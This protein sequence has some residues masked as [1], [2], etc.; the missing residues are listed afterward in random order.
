LKAVKLAKKS[1][2]ANDF[3]KNHFNPGSVPPAWRF[4]TRLPAAAMAT[5]RF[6]LLF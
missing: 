4:A 6:A 2:Q 1:E 5:H 3:N